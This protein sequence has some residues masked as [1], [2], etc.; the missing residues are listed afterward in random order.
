[1]EI[2]DCSIHFTFMQSDTST[3]EA[4]NTACLQ[5]VQA[6]FPRSMQIVF[7]LKRSQ[8]VRAAKQ[9]DVQVVAKMEVSGVRCL[10][11]VVNGC[12]RRVILT[13]TK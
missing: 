1:M 3:C 13:D 7:V 2:I 12:L 5:S 8:F 6:L 9:Q 10:S 11:F 4:S